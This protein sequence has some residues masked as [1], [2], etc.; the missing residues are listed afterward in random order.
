M[1]CV[2]TTLRA[3]APRNRIPPVPLADPPLDPAQ[4][5]G[6][7]FGEEIAHYM[8]CQFSSRR[9]SLNHEGG[10]TELVR[11][12]SNHPPVKGPAGPSMG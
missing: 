12:S 10:P 2:F 3:M 1:S 9:Q 6:R 8:Y 4:N 11:S 7:E 5:I